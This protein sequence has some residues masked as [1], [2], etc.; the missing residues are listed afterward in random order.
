MTVAG[1]AVTTVLAGCSGNGGDGGSETSDSGEATATETEED[2]TGGTSESD[3]GNSADAPPGPVDVL[4]S[5]FLAVDEGDISGANSYW[6]S[7]ASNNDR[8]ERR[9]DVVIDEIENPSIEQVSRDLGD[10][11]TTEELRDLGDG[12]AEDFNSEYDTG[13]SNW[14]YV[15]YSTELSGTRE[16]GYAWLAEV[17]D[18]WRIGTLGVFQM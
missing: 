5:F 17:P 14:T 7:Q 4:R 13:I 2:S 1:S 16:A 15:Y 8:P 6:L 18:G 11:A 10:D 12:W 9:R 3:G